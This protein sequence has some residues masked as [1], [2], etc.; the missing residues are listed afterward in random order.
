MNYTNLDFG[1]NALKAYWF[2]RTRNFIAR[3]LLKLG[4]KFGHW[5]ERTALAIAPWI[6]G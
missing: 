5:A 6:E 1:S 3:L 4:S 2:K